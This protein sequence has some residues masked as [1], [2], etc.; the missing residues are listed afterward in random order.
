MA[1]QNASDALK[2]I[3]GRRALAF[4][5]NLQKRIELLRDVLSY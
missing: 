4:P 2:L 5:D 3:T 1:L